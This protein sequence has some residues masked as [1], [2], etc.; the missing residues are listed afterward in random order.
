MSENLLLLQG[1]E[2]NSLTRGAE[3]NR[4]KEMA[5]CSKKST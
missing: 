1:G 2:K 5:L 4:R 3:S